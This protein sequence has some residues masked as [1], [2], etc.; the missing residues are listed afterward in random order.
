MRV[1][2][3]AS[4]WSFPLI[5]SVLL[6]L[7]LTPW[8]MTFAGVE[9]SLRDEWT[10]AWVI[11]RLESYSDCLD[12]YT[13]NLVQGDSVR[14][15]S[16]RHFD[17]GEL[18]QVRKVVIK[19]KG[20]NIL[21]DLVEPVLVPH[22]EGPVILYTERWC[23]IEFRI[24]VND[25]SATAQPGSAMMERYFRQF[26]EELM[27]RK[28]PSWNQRIR[29]AYP[30]NYLARQTAV[31]RKDTEDRNVAIEMLLEQAQQWV[32]VIVERL[33]RDS[34]YVAGFAH[35]IAERRQQNA[36]T[37]DTLIETGLAFFEGVQQGKNA[38]F[39]GVLDAERLYVALLLL[40]RLPACHQRT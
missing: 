8:N 4:Q 18:A 35:G 27:A 38:G 22:P 19:R 24:K 1:L 23:K 17:A 25:S 28:D 26:S 32:V 15:D 39:S 29:A 7:V 33:N 16:G 37:C 12:S 20:I 3:W 9:K 14:S 30:A 31:V 2:R 13:R 5:T 40:E 6:G 21:L 10:N 34:H 36:E 11:V